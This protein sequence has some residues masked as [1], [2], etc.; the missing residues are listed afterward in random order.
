M[1]LI[2]ITVQPFVSRKKS[3][4]K[5]RINDKSDEVKTGAHCNEVE[6]TSDPKIIKSSYIM[7]FIVMERATTYYI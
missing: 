1:V 3:T 4:T 7:S 2:K 5:T 6:C